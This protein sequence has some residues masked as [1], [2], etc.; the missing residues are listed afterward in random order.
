MLIVLVGTPAAGKRGVLDY[1]VQRSFA[2]LDLP[3]SKAHATAASTTTCFSIPDMLDLAT[4]NW[5]SQ[6]VTTSLRTYEE[7]EPF[8]KRPFVLVVAVDGPIRARFDRAVRR[9]E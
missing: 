4:R 9:G 2:V 1:L 8:L 3:N 7:L 5:Q 6:F